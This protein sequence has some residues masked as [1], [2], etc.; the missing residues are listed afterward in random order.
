MIEQTQ[1]LST[2]FLCSEFKLE[3]IYYRVNFLGKNVC[4]NFFFFAETNF[5]GSLKKSQ[6][7]NN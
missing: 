4:A 3:D 7:R 1:F 2:V 6:N 5:G